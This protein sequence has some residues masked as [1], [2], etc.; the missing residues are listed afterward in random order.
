MSDFIVHFYIAFVGVNVVA[1][2]SKHTQEYEIRIWYILRG[3]GKQGDSKTARWNCTCQWGFIL[4]RRK[5]FDKIDNDQLIQSHFATSTL[6]TGVQ[7][8]WQSFQWVCFVFKGVFTLGKIFFDK[9][10]CKVVDIFA[11]N[12]RESTVNRALDGSIY[13]G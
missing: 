9:N 8:D 13:L 4:W 3:Q 10:T 1:V 11:T 2:A 5:R 7:D 12:G 6:L